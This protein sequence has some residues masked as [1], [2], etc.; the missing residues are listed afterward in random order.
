MTAVVVKGALTLL[1]GEDK[2]KTGIRYTPAMPTIAHAAATATDY[3]G[4][5]RAPFDCRLR[6]A[7]FI[8]LVAVSGTDTNY[9]CLNLVNIGLA[10][11]G[12]TELAN[13]DLVAGADLTALA[14]NIITEG[15]TTD[16][17]AGDV[18][19]L[20]A[21]KVNDGVAI[22]VGYWIIGYDGG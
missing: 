3:I 20:Q 11:S 18:I 21:E 10:G 15:L 6:C 17:A 12:T 5:W 13:I 2:S 8:P 4:I 22:G 14:K 1:S 9:T 16:L 7:Y 19:G